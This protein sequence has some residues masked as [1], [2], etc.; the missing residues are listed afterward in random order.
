M[1]SG[2]SP[3]KPGSLPV[4]TLGST[5]FEYGVV[6]VSTYLCSSRSVV[7]S[8]PGR[9]DRSKWAGAG[10]GGEVWAGHSTTHFPIPETQEIFLVLPV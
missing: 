3:L 6:F 4:C 2:P 9:T 7:H 10:A 1:R 8:S 5:V